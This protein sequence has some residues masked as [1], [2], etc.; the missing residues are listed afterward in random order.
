M[1]R[2]PPI[3]LKSLIRHFCRIFSIDD[4]MFLSAVYAVGQPGLV[5]PALY[6]VH[7]KLKISKKTC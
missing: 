1:Y 7:R 3:L 5:P 2:F 4:I 6:I